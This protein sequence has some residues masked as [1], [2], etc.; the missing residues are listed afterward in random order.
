MK[1]RRR[2]LESLLSIDLIRR[3][4]YD[5]QMKKTLLFMM[6]SPLLFLGLTGCSAE[7]GTT[8]NEERQSSTD[9]AESSEEVTETS[10][11]DVESAC[12]EALRAV[13]QLNTLSDLFLDDAREAADGGADAANDAVRKYGPE[14]ERVAQGLLD[15]RVDDPDLGDTIQRFADAQMAFGAQ[16][17]M[18][19]YD[20]GR[21]DELADEAILAT[22]ELQGVCPE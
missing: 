8:E 20:S 9:M 21:E 13:S 22:V 18:G 5:E 6:C 1:S 7:S 4:G 12:D 11:L 15:L 3:D 14:Y 2:Q 10:G 17:T 19:F 16:V